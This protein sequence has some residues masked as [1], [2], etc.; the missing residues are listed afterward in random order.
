MG[1]HYIP[2]YYL[3]GFC[4]ASKSPKICRY[5]KGSSKVI[6]TI[7]KNVAHETDFY[8]QEMEKY[9]ADE[10]EG[11]ANH[12]LDKIRGC[13]TSF[14][15]KDKEPL[16]AYIVALLKRVPRGKE[17]LQATAP[18]ASQKVHQRIIAQ[19]DQYKEKYPEKSDLVEKRKQQTKDLLDDIARAVPKDIWL[20]IIAPE[21]SPQIL[22]ALIAMTWR[23]FVWEGPIG[24]I[25]SDNPVFF[26]ESLGI[27]N[28]RCEVTF[29]IS[30]NIALWATWRNDLREGYV[31]ST[32]EALK[33][34]NMRTASFATRYLFYSHNEPW[35][36]NLANRK[37]FN[38]TYLV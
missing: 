11:P 15:S 24:L 37:T 1:D 26:F 10:V 8:S 30:K 35:V 18:R 32:P 3:R 28:E 22:A 12:V 16:A 38:Y 27:G 36:R 17:R 21:K 13:S 23:F 34:I 6:T 29:P 25:T 14:S 2:Q 4:S 9:L 33:E 20:N 7:I 31:R 19:L 5:E